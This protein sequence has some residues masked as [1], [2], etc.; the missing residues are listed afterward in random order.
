M[1]HSGL[2]ALF[3][4]PGAVA[5]SCNDAGATEVLSKVPLGGIDPLAVCNDGT[6]ASY[7]IKDNGNRNHWMVYLAG[8]GWCYDADSCAGRYNGSQYPHH[9]CRNSSEALPCFMSSKDYPE[10]CAKTGMFDRSATDR[11][12]SAVAAANKIYVPYCSSDGHMGDGEFEGFQY[13]GARIA[14]AVMT[15]LVQNKGLGKGATLVFGGGSAGGRGAMTL[16]DEVSESM[17]PHGVRV[18]GLLDS[19]YYIDIPSF[20]DDFAGFQPQHPRVLNNFNSHSVVSWRCA[21]AHAGEEW[22]CLFGVFRMPFVETPYLLIQ[23]SNDGWQLSHL[24]HAYSGIEKVPN[25]TASE[26]AYAEHFGAQTV[27]DLKQLRVPRGSIKYSQACYN[28]HI[29]EKALF[30]SVTT[31]SGVSQNEALTMFLSGADSQK[32]T[33]DECTEFDCGAGCYGRP[34][35]LI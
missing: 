25:Y 17:R 31:S 8:G 11:E 3:S 5:W 21:E 15:D 19:P 16:L 1:T 22:K 34:T 23:S 32:T 29:T 13:R 10:T 4:L 18:L 9:D 7:Y 20:S 28:H 14:R 30:F 35:A 33:I 27:Q 2:L 26:T 6:E 12:K 24:V